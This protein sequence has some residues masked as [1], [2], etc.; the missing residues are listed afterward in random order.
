MQILKSVSPK[1][2]LPAICSQY[3]DVGFYIGMFELCQLSAKKLD[4]KDLGMQ[5]YVNGGPPYSLEQVAYTQ[6]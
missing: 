4:P 6:R 2:N 3:V 1:I 5:Y